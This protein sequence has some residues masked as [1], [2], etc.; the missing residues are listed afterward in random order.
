[1]FINLLR[2]KLS[3]ISRLTEY[4]IS[5]VSEVNFCFHLGHMA[6]RPPSTGKLTPVILE[7]ALEA[8]KKD[9]FCNLF[10]YTGYSK[11]MGC[12]SPFQKLI[13]K[14]YFVHKWNFNTKVSLVHTEASFMRGK[15][16]IWMKKYIAYSWEHINESKVL[17]TYVLDES[18]TCFCGHKAK[19]FWKPVIKIRSPNFYA[20][21]GTI[22]VQIGQFFDPPSVFKDL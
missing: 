16:R 2:I 1:M 12:F 5:G 22:W 6:C 10:R 4:A 3:F 11:G 19:C 9:H 18:L 15:I 20:S 13:R 17:H 21:F 7:A 8:K 14:K